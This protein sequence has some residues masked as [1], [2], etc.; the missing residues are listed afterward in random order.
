MLVENHYTIK[1][2]LNFSNFFIPKDKVYSLYS[3]E[4]K[5]KSNEDIEIRDVVA[6]KGF[7]PELY[8]MI[9]KDI[10]KDELYVQLMTS[11]PEHY[12]PIIV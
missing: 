10:I 4:E 1:L 6:L 7:S 8:Q 2:G 5:N 11:D 9:V 3:S 12:I